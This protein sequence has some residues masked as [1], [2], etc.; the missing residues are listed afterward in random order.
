MLVQGARLG[1]DAQ[2]GGRGRDH[3]RRQRRRE[4]ARPAAR[5]EQR[6]QICAAG[7]KAAVRAGRLAERADVHVH[8]VR[9]TGRLRRAAAAARG[10]RGVVRRHTRCGLAYMDEVGLEWGWE[11]ER[12]MG[13][14][15]SP[16]HAS[17]QLRLVCSARRRRRAP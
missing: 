4:D 11:W 2:R 3:R 17:H 6:A 13:Q 8:L 15:Y 16:D 7:D 9:H 14:T 12:F 10:H 5:D 1:G